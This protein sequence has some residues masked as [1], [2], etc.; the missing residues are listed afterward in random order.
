MPRIVGTAPNGDIIYEREDGSQFT[1]PA[2]LG[3][4]IGITAGADAPQQAPAPLLQPNFPAAEVGPPDAITGADHAPPQ[5]GPGVVTPELQAEAQAEREQ[6]ARVA[7]ERAMRGSK[8]GLEEGM[9]QTQLAAEDAGMAAAESERAANTAEVAAQAADAARREKI[10]VERQ[11]ALDR[12]NEERR[13]AVAAQMDENR[14]T[15]EALLDSTVDPHRRF[16]NMGV[17]GKISTALS[18]AMGGLMRPSLGGRN[19]AL[20]AVESMISRDI[21]AQLADIETKKSAYAMQ[22]TLLGRL[23]EHFKDETTAVELAT[24]AALDWAITQ[25]DKDMAGARSHRVQ[26]DYQLARQ[27]LLEKRDAHLQAADARLHRNAEFEFETEFKKKEQLEKMRHN[28]AQEGIARGHLGVAVSRLQ[29]DRDKFMLDAAKSLQG[30]SEDP[31]LITTSLFGISVN[32]ETNWR[33]RTTKGAEYLKE[34]IPVRVNAI[35]EAEYILAF[36]PSRMLPGTEGRVH[37]AQAV[38]RLL[39][40]W[41]IRAGRDMSQQKIER[42][43]KSISAAGDDPGKLAR[44]MSD[45]TLRQSISDFITSQQRAIESDIFTHAWHPEAAG[46]GETRITVNP[47]KPLVPSE[48]RAGLGLNTV[49]AGLREQNDPAQVAGL[50]VGFTKLNA[51]RTSGVTLPDG[52]QG[53]ISLM[54]TAGGETLLDLAEAAGARAKQASPGENFLHMEI[55]AALTTLRQQSQPGQLV[56]NVMEEQRTREA[57]RREVGEDRARS[58]RAADRARFG[59]E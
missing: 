37:M 22:N 58:R 2:G 10:Q 53:P 29:L 48:P 33:A 25:L 57:D 28:R 41:I 4:D 40:D 1:I 46:A 20:E 23:F 42:L 21:D 51:T 27:G 24:A 18:V 31:T 17:V 30:D 39:A 6:Q 36:D 19:P 43:S 45:K 38:N 11:D 15:I 59:L 55:D 35:R 44:L 14:A 9:M 26:K 7:Q 3:R 49:I 16:R 50:L 47:P 32:G 5:R 54:P 8:A 12:V 34:N 13:Q 52:R 56:P